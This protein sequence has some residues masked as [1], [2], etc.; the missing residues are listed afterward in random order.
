MS[1][2]SFKVST[3]DL[4]SYYLPKS[5]SYDLMLSSI[6]S[7]GYGQIIYNYYGPGNFQIN[8]YNVWDG[9]LQ[10]MVVKTPDLSTTYTESQA[11]PALWNVDSATGIQFLQ[12]IT[13][14]VG[15]AKLKYCNSCQG[16]N[17]LPSTTI[18]NFSNR[19]VSL[20]SMK[21]TYDQ[22]YGY[23]FYDYDFPN[24]QDWYISVYDTTFDKYVFK[25]YLGTQKNVL[26][27]SEETGI[28]VVSITASLQSAEPLIP[29][30]CDTINLSYSTT[31]NNV[32]DLVQLQYN[33][34]STNDVLYNNESCGSQ[35][36]AIGYYSDGEN[37]FY[38]DGVNFDKFGRCLTPFEG[39]W[40]TS[41]SIIDQ[42]GM[43]SD[44]T[45]E[46]P[47]EN[48]YLDYTANENMSTII[49]SFNGEIWGYSIEMSTGEM[50]PSGLVY[51]P[52]SYYAGTGSPVA[53]AMDMFAIDK[54]GNPFTFYYFNGYG[55]NPPFSNQLFLA[56]VISPTTYSP[57][58]AWDTRLFSGQYYRQRIY[59]FWQ[60][61]GSYYETVVSAGYVNSTA[62]IDSQTNYFNGSPNF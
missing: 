1:Y 16:R 59:P 35:T 18:S 23:L 61:L 56:Q 43:T 26:Q 54:D 52:I 45:G 42:F 51:G 53:S 19:F 3:A 49:P 2:Q 29:I 40:V 21:R 62:T 5:F 11:G 39:P 37:V 48:L 50:S 22:K 6:N 32:C 34:D 17:G 7:N 10:S 13:D 24:N 8:S 46:Y 55:S 41:I 25:N 27:V 9:E 57:P 36:A 30:V 38:W 31:P 14:I 12:G 15:I 4:E 33:Y 28:P 20:D 60:N 47:F 58:P 44:P